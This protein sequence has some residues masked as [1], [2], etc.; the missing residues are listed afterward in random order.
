MR[1]A[2]LQ[3]LVADRELALRALQHAQ[4][5]RAVAESHA[6]TR[7]GSRMRSRC[8]ASRSHVVWLTSAASEELSRWARAIDQM[9]LPNSSTS[10]FHAASSP[11]RAEATREA[12]ACASRRLER[13]LAHATPTEG[14]DDAETR[15][16]TLSAD[17][18]RWP[19]GGVT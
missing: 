8:S 18:G 9:R 5:C 3:Q 15:W 10:A 12:T 11:S 17:G 4:T 6:P 14:L 19:Q 2:R 1:P 7:S 16:K 13:E